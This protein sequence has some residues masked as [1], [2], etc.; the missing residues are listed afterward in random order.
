MVATDLR[1]RRFNT[2]AGEI[3][4]LIPADVGRT[5]GDLRLN[6]AVPELQRLLANV[7]GEVIIREREVQDD[8]GHWYMLRIQP[9]RTADHRIDGAVVVLVSIDGSNTPKKRAAI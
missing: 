3:C 5:I 1:I 6:V 7:I 2:P 8:E 4:N 9:Y